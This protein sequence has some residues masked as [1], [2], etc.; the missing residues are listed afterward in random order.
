M[1]ANQVRAF[2]A[3]QW[4]GAMRSPLAVACAAFASADEASRAV[5]LAQLRARAT[6]VERQ[7]LLTDA[8]AHAN[9]CIA[10]RDGWCVETLGHSIQSAFAPDLDADA[11]DEIARVAL[12]AVEKES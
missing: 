7:Q 3:A 6:S 5:D 12:A 4:P 8:M 10:A 9:D 1:D 2:V 11:C